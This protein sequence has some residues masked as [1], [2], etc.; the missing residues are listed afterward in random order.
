[1]DL[2]Q[3]FPLIETERLLLRE[4]SLEQD[5][6]DYVYIMAEEEVGSWLPKGQGYT[7]EETIKF[8]EFIKSH[9]EKFG[10]GIWAVA[11]KVTGSLLGHCG[12][13]YIESL[14]EVEVLYAFGSHGRGKGYCTEAAK[15]SLDFAFFDL[16]M[17]HIIALAKP[18][19]EASRNVM[20]KLGLKYIKDIKLFNMDCVYYDI[21]FGGDKN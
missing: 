7:K 16:N 1:M 6:N 20:E 17:D 4:F 15:A 3:G 9:W 21:W 8:M 2:V 13:N 5:L 10:F 14:K 19:N 18:G 12:L 11:D